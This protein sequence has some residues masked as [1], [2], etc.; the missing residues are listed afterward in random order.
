M[1]TYNEDGTWRTDTY[2]YK[3]VSFPWYAPLSSL[4]AMDSFEVRK[5][6]VWICTYAKSGTGWMGEVVWRILSYSGAINTEEPL[7]KCIYPD[8]HYRG[9]RPNY[10]VIAE[11]PSPRIVATHLLPSFLPP[12]LFDVH[13]KIIYLARNPKDIAVSY[14]HHLTVSP[15]SPSY[16]TYQDFLDEF[17]SGQIILG[18]WPSH[19]TYWWKKKDDDNVLFLK[20]EDMKKD[21]RRTV[22]MICNF[23]GKSLSTETLERIAAE[24]TFK[25]MKKRKVRGHICDFLKIDP[26][27]S[28]F[29][30]KG[31]V[32]GWKEHFTVAQNEAIDKWYEQAV[33]GT[34]LSFDF[35]PKQI[36]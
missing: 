5:D 8:F 21:L 22:E 13:P 16:N 9:P 1:N 35:L 24:C 17:L 10:E 12:Q 18:D 30:R 33:E 25:E 32:G 11:M 31:R 26:S 6:D 34:G 4:K 14:H 23:L 20:Y 36:S 15:V 2:T 19:V 27:M 3:G 7:D 29:V 28:P